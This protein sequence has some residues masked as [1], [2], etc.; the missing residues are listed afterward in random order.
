MRMVRLKQMCPK[1]LRE[2]SLLSYFLFP[3]LFTHNIIGRRQG[4]SLFSRPTD[5][6]VGRL[7]FRKGS[8]ES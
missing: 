7:G 3:E 8:I 6:A 5:T 2:N 4:S 1:R